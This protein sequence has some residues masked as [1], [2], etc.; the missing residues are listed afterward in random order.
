MHYVGFFRLFQDTYCVTA[1]GLDNQHNYGKVTMQEKYD[2]LVAMIKPLPTDIP[3]LKW[4]PSLEPD[5]SN[6]QDQPLNN[7]WISLEEV[8]D[9]NLDVVRQAVSELGTNLAAALEIGVNRNG[10]RSMSRIIMDQRPPL[11]YYMGIDI[12]D[13]SYL[14]DESANTWTMQISSAER[15]KISDRLKQL[16]I[17]NLDLIM[18]DGWHSVNMCVNDWQFT[19]RLSDH[20]I[21]LLHDTNTHPGC[22]ALFEA[23]DERLWIKQRFCLEH[24]FGIATFRKRI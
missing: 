10:D 13:K 6:D 23:V 21:V 7:Y 5:V 1:A 14:N 24:D 11:S 19:E 4:F 18:I 3:G 8:S 20:G 9:G 22:V 12:E 15:A 17:G 16:G 2:E